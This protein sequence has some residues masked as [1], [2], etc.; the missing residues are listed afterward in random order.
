[1]DQDDKA[2]QSPTSGNLRSV[3]VQIVDSATVPKSLLFGAPRFERLKARKGLNEACSHAV[4]KNTSTL[5][6]AQ[7]K[8]GLSTLKDS[9]GDSREATPLS[10]F[11]RS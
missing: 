10:A 6:G 4:S 2:L 7:I 5:E 11:E 8:S 1:M 3:E 9:A